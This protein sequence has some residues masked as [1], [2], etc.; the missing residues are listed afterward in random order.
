MTDIIDKCDLKSN[1]ADESSDLPIREDNAR[2]SEQ[3]L[4]TNW[5]KRK[6]TKNQL[7]TSLRCDEGEVSMSVQTLSTGGDKNVE[8]GM[9]KTIKSKVMAYE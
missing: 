3:N 9:D 2:H 6:R 5:S 4:P 1:Q 8:K 7:L